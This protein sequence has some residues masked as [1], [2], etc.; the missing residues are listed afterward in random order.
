[1]PWSWASAAYATIL[2][3]GVV[4]PPPLVGFVTVWRTT[5]VNETI[6]LPLTGS[7]YNATV[8]WGDG[9]PDS[10]ITLGNTDP[11]RIHAYAVAGDHTVTITGT[12]PKFFFNN[13]G[14]KA[15]LIKILNWGAVGWASGGLVS[16]FHGCVNLNEVSATDCANMPG[17]S[18]NRV[19]I[20]CSSLTSINLTGAPAASITVLSDLLALCP[21]L[22]TAVLP[23]LCTAAC[24]SLAQTF[25]GCVALTSIVGLETWITTNVTNMSSFFASCTSLPAAEV[26]KVAGFNTAK[27]TNFDK[28]FRY[29]NVP[30]PVATWTTPAATLMPYMFGDVKQVSVN[31]AHFDMGLVTNAT[32]MYQATAGVNG[33]T[34]AH[35]DAML[36][37]WAAQSPDLKPA[38]PFTATGVKFSA[39]AATTARGVLTGTHTW[40]ITDGGPAA[41]L[42]NDQMQ[43]PVED[44]STRVLNVDPLGN[45]WNVLT[46]SADVGEGQTVVGPGG[47]R[48]V[49]NAGSPNV[50]ITAVVQAFAPVGLMFRSRVGGVRSMRVLLNMDGT[51][52][53]QRVGNGGAVTVVAS[54]AAMPAAD[55]EEHHLQIWVDAASRIIVYFDGVPLIDVVDAY[56]MN[57]PWHGILAGPG[58]VYLR[59]FSIAQ[60]PL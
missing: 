32:L 35:Y 7:G 60:F 36:I 12:F 9:T 11:A 13:A 56:Q 53:L 8:N 49:I 50:V 46:G 28:T 10:L 29:I 19:F 27:V 38:V 43:G 41:L 34:T 52:E 57:R 1:V 40:A 21:A 26:A 16:A 22:V 4:V 45:G 30:I 20:S 58:A 15:K 42:V 55:T 17:G 23:G 25:G 31:S 37:A 59:E 24:T 5:A 51:L 33:L 14:D 6:T 39:G 18:W 54:V 2:T 44:V 48:A 3:G 47:V